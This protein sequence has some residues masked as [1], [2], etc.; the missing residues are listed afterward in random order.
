M[1]EDKQPAR[2]VPWTK[3]ILSYT[4]AIGGFCL[5]FAGAY[6]ALYFY[7]NDLSLEERTDSLG[8]A[9]CLLLM[10]NVLMFFRLLK[11]SG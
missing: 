9:L 10:T 6:V 3:E 1:D 5:F 7:K 8:N 2:R 11:R 4:S